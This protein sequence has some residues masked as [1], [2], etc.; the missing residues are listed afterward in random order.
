MH[1]LCTYMFYIALTFESLNY[2]Y[3]YTVDPTFTP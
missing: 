1:F 3:N 2:I